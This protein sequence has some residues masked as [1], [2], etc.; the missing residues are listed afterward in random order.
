MEPSIGRFRHGARAPPVGVA[1]GVSR[2]LAARDLAVHQGFADRVARE[3]VRACR[4]PHRLARRVEPRHGAPHAG[5]HLHPAH[6]VVRDRRDLDGPAREVDAVLQQPVDHRPESGAKLRLGYVGE[7]QPGA[8]RRRAAARVDLAADRIRREVPGRGVPAVVLAAVAVNELLH[9]AVQQPAAELVAEGVPHDGVHADE[10]RR[11]VADREELHELHVHQRRARAQREG[12][13]FARHVVRGARPRVEPGEPAGRDHRRPG[14]D[15]DLR[16]VTEREAE[17]PAHRAFL[18]HEIGDRDV[19]ERADAGGPAHPLAQRPG[20]RRP[21]V[22]EI[23]VAAAP[24]AVAR[25]HDLAD[26]AGVTGGTIRAGPADP[27]FVHL[28]HPLGRVPAQHLGERCVAEPATGREG[29]G[30]MVF[31][32]VRLLL[33]KRGGDGHLGHDRRP[34]APDHVLVG[35]DDIDAGARRGDGGVHAGAAGADDEDVGGE[36]H[37]VVFRPDRV[38]PGAAAAVFS[39]TKMSLKG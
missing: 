5:V 3:P 24:P 31:P 2:R 27:P 4:A 26:A 33:G 13:A 23:D 30:E 10:A 1:P 39:N 6:V 16:A 14:G 18:H 36:V 9:L 32:G 28:A 8:S 37:D 12:V 22:Q 11:E 7:R 19:A 17:R 38:L 25:R 34:S 35:E 29:V 21:G 20:H 15:L